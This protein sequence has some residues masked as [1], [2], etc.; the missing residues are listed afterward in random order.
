MQKRNKVRDC[1]QDFCKQT[2]L[3]GWHYL[4]QDKD[5][6]AN[7]LK[8]N[9]RRNEEELDDAAAE[10]KKNKARKSTNLSTNTRSGST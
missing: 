10:L 3:H 7:G 6:D 9:S 5:E 8:H 2:I 4:V 1:G